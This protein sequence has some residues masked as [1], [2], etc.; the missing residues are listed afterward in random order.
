L[1]FMRFSKHRTRSYF[2]LTGLL[3]GLM[4][5]LPTFADNSQA[6]EQGSAEPENASVSTASKNADKASVEKSEMIHNHSLKKDA[7]NGSESG[8]AS[9]DSALKGTEQSAAEP[10][11]QASA[12]PPE[13]QPRPKKRDPLALKPGQ[14]L[15]IAGF[16]E[17]KAVSVV[18]LDAVQPA[19]PAYHRAQMRLTGSMCYA[20]LHELQDKLLDVYGV[21]RVRIEKSEQPS[22]AAYAPVLP[23]WAD[24][25][26]FF[27]STKV[28]LQ[29]LRA[30]MRANAY[31]PYKVT[32]KSVD[33][34]P[35][36]NQKRI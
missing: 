1:P 29:D 22:I 30:Y 34:V 25:I 5:V 24:A 33:S 28:D 20:C 19:N 12:P 36:E 13:N 11:D 23:N 14:K 8:A 31:F 17:Q 32:E 2:Q 6:S 3:I 27:D 7:E 21:E 9:P 18:D 15:K 26:V 10:A 16:A 4:S 35:P